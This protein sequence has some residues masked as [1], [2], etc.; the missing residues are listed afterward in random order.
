MTLI[1]KRNITKKLNLLFSPDVVVEFGLEV[2]SPGVAVL[3]PG[4]ESVAGLLLRPL[5]L[6]GAVGDQSIR[7]IPNPFR[8][9]AARVGA[10]KI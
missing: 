7:L 2:G 5:G 3:D 6:G 1:C 4:A 8:L 9:G 10:K